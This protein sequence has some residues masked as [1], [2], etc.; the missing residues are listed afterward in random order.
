MKKVIASIFCL[1][2]ITTSLAGCL[3]G[4]DGNSETETVPDEPE[5]SDWD[6]YH[7]DSGADLP[8]CN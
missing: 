7:V 1:L 3:G 6:I 8:N 2:M 4:D 5:L